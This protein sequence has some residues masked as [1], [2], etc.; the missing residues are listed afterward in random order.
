MYNGP[1]VKRGGQRGE[2]QFPELLPQE[3][4]FFG[5]EGD[6]GEGQTNRH[7][8]GEQKIC[9][10]SGGVWLVSQGG[11]KKRLS[12]SRVTAFFFVLLSHIL[13]RKSGRRNIFSL[14][15]LSLLLPHFCFPCSSEV[16]NYYY[17]SFLFRSPEKINALVP[18]WVTR[19]DGGKNPRF[20]KENKNNPLRVFFGNSQSVKVQHCCIQ[21]YKV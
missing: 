20:T 5:E 11:R 7:C 10:L 15:F 2:I 1:Q 21:I 4:S 8:Q 3:E 18:K 9:V 16:C 12:C 13:S 6:K 19:T 14:I 17:T